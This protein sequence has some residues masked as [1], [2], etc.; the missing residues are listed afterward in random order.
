[1]AESREITLRIVEGLAS[2]LY[3]QV[4][5]RG[6]SITEQY[7]RDFIDTYF[8]DNLPRVTPLS[9]V[10]VDYEAIV[11][12]LQQT[13]FANESWRDVLT[14][15]TGQTIVEMFAQVAG[16]NALSVER[17]AQETMLDTARLPSSI[18]TIARHLG[19][20]VQR[21][22]PA[23]VS[24]RLTNTDNSV[25][26][27]IE[28]Y[29]PFKVEQ[30]WFFN[31]EPIIFHENDDNVLD[32]ILY[33]GELIEEQFQSSG[34]AFQRFEIGFGDFSISDTDIQINVGKDLYTRVID[35]LWKY[36]SQEQVF[37]ENT[38]PNGSVEVMF[39]NGIYGKMPSVSTVISI[40]YARTKGAEGNASTIALR[41]T[42]PGEQK[43]SGTTLGPVVGGS[44]HRDKEFYRTLAPHI[45]SARDR[46]VT[47]ADYE[48]LAFTFSEANIVDCRFR[49]QAEI[50]PNNRSW[51]NVV[52]ATLL[53]TDG[54]TLSDS[55]W[56]TF[57]K[58]IKSKSIHSV[59]ILRQDPI[60]VP[61]R[62]KA[63][64]F[65]R[66]NANLIDIKRLLE[67]QIAGTFRPKRYC[68]GY[69]YYRSDIHE[70]LEAGGSWRGQVTHAILDEPGTDIEIGQLE[71]ATLQSAELTVVYGTRDY[72]PRI[73]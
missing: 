55:E 59:E 58:F 7:V 29:T 71:W 4:Q 39:G 17:A 68:L 26:V 22:Q 53:K 25:S 12:Q 19:V 66:P 9:N 47:R 42:V 6:S 31:R 15:G 35:G 65:C 24:C 50:A 10:L 5:E 46:A 1:M 20:H 52:S 40:R 72:A 23:R 41:V 63:R 54:T 38:L 45:Y 69:S 18:Y 62:I 3:E 33:E 61:L 60:S 64:V 57:V 51:M 73:S 13:L 2:S 49:G 21:R 70:M 8:T 37:Y 14:A 32:V 48:A 56:T 27:V 28:P 16:Y 34:G 30:Y 36:G 43:I 67:A 11:L 44:A